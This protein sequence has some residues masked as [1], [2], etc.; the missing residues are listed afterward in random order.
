MTP[1][2]SIVNYLGVLKLNVI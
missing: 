1:V 2:Y